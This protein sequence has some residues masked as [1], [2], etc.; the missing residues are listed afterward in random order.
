LAGAV[1]VTNPGPAPCTVEGR[2]QVRI[3]DGGAELPVSQTPGHARCEFVRAA[4]SLGSQLELAIGGQA[5]AWLV[6]GNWCQPLPQ[7]LPSLLVSVSED[8]GSVLNTGV[9]DVATG[10]PRCNAADEPSGL[11]VGPFEPIS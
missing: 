6:W 1:I 11:A 3:L 2:P 9:D 5:M 4:C 10:A 7:G 8:P